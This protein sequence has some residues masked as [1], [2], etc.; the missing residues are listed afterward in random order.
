MVKSGDI[1]SLGIPPAF[2]T[3]SISPLVSWPGQTGP[4]ETRFS[5]EFSRKQNLNNE[6]HMK[7][8]MTNLAN[9]CQGIP[10]REKN[11]RPLALLPA[12]ALVLVKLSCWFAIDWFTG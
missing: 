6:L 11:M 12:L 10:W 2:K 9:L 3:L 7:T 5:L 1:A 8:H 4:C